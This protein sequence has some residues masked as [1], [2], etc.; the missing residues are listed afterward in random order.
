MPGKD[1][2]IIAGLLSRGCGTYQLFQRDPREFVVSSTPPL[3]NVLYRAAGQTEPS[4]SRRRIE[5]GGLP[6]CPHEISD[7]LFSRHSSYP[8]INTLSSSEGSAL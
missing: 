8:E 5:P 6:P 3:F 4:T 7:G 2:T 1:K